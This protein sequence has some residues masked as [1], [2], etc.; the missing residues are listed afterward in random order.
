[1][2]EFCLL[3]STGAQRR[4]KIESGVT[5]EKKGEHGEDEEMKEVV[6]V[7]GVDSFYSSET[8]FS[9]H[10]SFLSVVDPLLLLLLPTLSLSGTQDVLSRSQ[11]RRRAL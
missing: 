1:M 2:R 11:P 10:F 6:E 3:F 4:K 5:V 9:H 7:V 8:K